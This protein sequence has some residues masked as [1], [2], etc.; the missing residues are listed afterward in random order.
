MKPTKILAAAL[1]LAAGAGL[2]ACDDISEEERL[3]PVDRPEIKRVVLIQEFTGMWCSNCPQGA[4]AVH[5]AINANPGGIVAVSLH[6]KSARTFTRPAPASMGGLDLAS[7]EADVYMDYWGAN[8]F[9]TAVIN[10]SELLT[11]PFSGWI[12]A[13][14]QALQVEAPCDLQVTTDYD[15]AT[16]ELKADWNVTFNKVFTGD[17]SVMLWIVENDIVGFQVDNGHRLSDY[18]HNHV[19][20]STMNGAWGEQIDGQVF[21]AD[22]TATGSGSVTLKDDWVAENCKV[23]AFVFQTAS[24][25][26]EQAAEASIN[27]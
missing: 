16:R 27:E 5:D 14:E 7:E 24:K 9:P 26:V 20:R 8:A 22:D 15:P 2:T 18:V 4:Q 10:G 17:L 11:I 21:I 25:A 6:P 1:L 23:V 19:F 3:I 12:T 13:A